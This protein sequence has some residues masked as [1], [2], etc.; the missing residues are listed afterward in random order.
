MKHM[1]DIGLEDSPRVTQAVIELP[2][3]VWGSLIQKD[4]PMIAEKVSLGEKL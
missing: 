4:N 1:S 3:D 2:A